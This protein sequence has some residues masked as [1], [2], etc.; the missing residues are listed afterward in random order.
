M[1]SGR[2]AQ[3]RIR[4]RKRVNGTQAV[5]AVSSGRGKIVGVR[6]APS[7]IATMRREIR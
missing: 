1:V 6:R 5:E 7:Q 3:P 2:P 4:K